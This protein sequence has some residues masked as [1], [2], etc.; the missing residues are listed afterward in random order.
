MPHSE[1]GTPRLRLNVHA[2]DECT[3][4][5]ILDGNLRS[6]ALKENLGELSLELPAGVYV[7]RFHQGGGQR[8]N[9]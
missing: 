2:N 8:S 5:E 6:V 7:V 4:I 3:R 1:H 9:Q